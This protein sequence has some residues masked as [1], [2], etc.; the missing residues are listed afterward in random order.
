MAVKYVCDRCGAEVSDSSKL[1]KV[2]IK[3]PLNTALING[4]EGYCDTCMN[5]VIDFICN[6]PKVVDEKALELD[7]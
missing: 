3:N 5:Q 7:F 6:P 2:S 4:E 1:Y